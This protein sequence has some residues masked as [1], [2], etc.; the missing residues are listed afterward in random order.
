MHMSFPTR[1]D[2][3]AVLYTTQIPDS[4]HWAI[5]ISYSS[6][7]VKKFHAKEYFT[8]IFCYEEPIPDEDLTASPTAYLVVKLGK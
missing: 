8:G 5:C 7:R 6:T 2:I 1:D 3:C 4:Y